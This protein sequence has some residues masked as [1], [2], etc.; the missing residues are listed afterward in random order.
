MFM[1]YG[2]CIYKYVITNNI[3]LGS[4]INNR[5]SHVHVVVNDITMLYPCGVWCSNCSPPPPPLLPLS[6]S[7]PPSPD[8]GVFVPEE[9][10]RQEYVL[11]ESGLIWAGTHDDMFTWP[12]NFAQVDASYMYMY[13]GRDGLLHIAAR[14]VVCCR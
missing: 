2:T 12:W 13:G 7:P 3:K 14:G 8:D 1:P 11:N 10:N 6:P 4:V 9:S 5:T